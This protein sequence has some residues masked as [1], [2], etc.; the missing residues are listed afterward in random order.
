MHTAEIIITFISNLEYFKLTYR[1]INYL[2]KQIAFYL[3][4]KHHEINLFIR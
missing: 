3:P 4:N 2:K 1:K